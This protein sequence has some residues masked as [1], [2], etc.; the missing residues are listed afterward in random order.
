MEILR[1]DIEVWL[2]TKLEYQWSSE[3][4]SSLLTKEILQGSYEIFSLLESS[5][6][7]KYLFSFLTLRKQSFQE[8]KDSI[9]PI[10][11]LA[12]NDSDQWVSVVAEQIYPILLGIEN[13]F[14]SFQNKELISPIFEFKIPEL[15]KLVEEIQT[16]TFS[17]YQKQQQAKIDLFSQQNDFND[18]NNNNNASNNTSHSGT[19]LILIFYFV[20]FT[21]LF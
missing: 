4:I 19:L 16:Q 13:N 12:K 11:D 9:Y 21:S 10:I 14:T 5:I 18:G 20:N 7:I 8:L 15:Q 1:G 3:N 17:Y 6:K 2:T